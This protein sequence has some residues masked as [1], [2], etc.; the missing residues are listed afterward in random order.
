ML[1]PFPGPNRLATRDGY[2]RAILGREHSITF[3]TVPGA[4]PSHQQRRDW[5]SRDYEENRQAESEDESM[6]DGEED[7]SIKRCD[8]VLVRKQDTALRKTV[9]KVSKCSHNEF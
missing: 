5:F 3:I 8:G 2:S 6:G 9:S 7:S 4:D 1:F